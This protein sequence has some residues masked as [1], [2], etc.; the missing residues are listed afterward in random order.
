MSEYVETDLHVYCSDSTLLKKIQELAF[1][2]D[3]RGELKFTMKKLLPLPEGFETKFGY[4]EFGHH[5]R[6]IL[7]GVKQDGQEFHKNFKENT[8]DVHF[9]TSNFPGNKW[10]ETFCQISEKLYN[11]C[12]IIPKPEL[13]VLYAYGIFDTED[14]GF[15]CWEPGKGIVLEQEF[16]EENRERYSSLFGQKWIDRF[17]D[18]W[19]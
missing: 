9:T 10:F 7:W 17:G 8:F 19:Y 5:W 13:V 18:V 3:K 14:Q 11:D 4:Q 12:E 6:D 15:V 1:S 16:P 2:K